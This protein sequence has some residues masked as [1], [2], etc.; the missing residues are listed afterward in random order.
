MSAVGFELS[1]VVFKLY[2]DMN[3][4]SRSGL[5]LEV[6]AAAN[7][8]DLNKILAKAVISMLERQE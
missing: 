8:F 4:T 3:T 2:R 1:T 6:V 7:V 5:A